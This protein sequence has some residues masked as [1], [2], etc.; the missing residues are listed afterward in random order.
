M[1]YQSIKNKTNVQEII[2]TITDDKFYEFKK[3]KQSTANVFY[4]LKEKIFKDFETE[5][6][7][8]GRRYK[9]NVLV[10]NF[11]SL[12]ISVLI[13]LF[14]NIFIFITVY[15]FSEPIKDSSFRINCS[16]YYIKN[17]RL[18]K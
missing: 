9:S 15:N 14:V 17:Y 1:D 12:I 13:F 7:S 3:M 4:F 10:L 11:V 8:F 5:A 16:F 6:I 18:T 2:D